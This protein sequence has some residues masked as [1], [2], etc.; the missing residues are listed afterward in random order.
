MISKKNIIERAKMTILMEANAINDLINHIDDNF[1]KVVNLIAN[2][3]GRI[4][5]TGV[6]KS[7]VIGMKIV[8]TLNST[9]TPSIFMHAGDATH[10]DLGI[11]QTNDIVICISKSGNSSEIKSLI[12]YLKKEKI[13][14][15]GMTSNSNSFL[16][17]NSD[18]ILYTPVKREA[19]P[20]N[21]APTTSTSV[22]LSMG[23]ALAMCLLEQNKFETKDFA[24]FHPGGSLGKRLFLTVGEMI[25]SKKPPFVSLN[26][27]LKNI[28]NEIMVF[29]LRPSMGLWTASWL[30]PAGP[31]RASFPDPGRCFRHAPP[32]LKSYK[33]MMIFGLPPS[34]GPWTASR[35]LPPRP[36]RASFPGQLYDKYMTII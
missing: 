35:P 9:G 31:Q 30:L 14:I 34:V 20:N 4:V 29:V 17:S 7:G 21:L 27:P 32:L 6:G 28:I 26:D 24:K 18:F 12:P 5:V 33:E 8:A 3:K 19:C 11:I 22:Q 13:I 25:K 36:L 2:S 23:D 15:V 1:V 10:G 16:S